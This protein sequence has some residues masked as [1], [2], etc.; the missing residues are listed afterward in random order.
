MGDLDLLIRHE[1]LPA[2]AE[3]LVSLGNSQDASFNASGTLAF[4]N[5]IPYTKNG[6]E[7]L[8]LDIHWNLF[9]WI[10]YSKTLPLKWFWETAL[11]A[12]SG[13]SPAGILGPEAQVLYLCGH[14]S[15]HQSEGPDLLW[16]NDIDEVVRF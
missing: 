14:L 7:Q 5:A 12:D 15:K 9:S 1:Q 6:D 3:A 8:L 2:A 16:L 13:L 11:C 4:E 10:F